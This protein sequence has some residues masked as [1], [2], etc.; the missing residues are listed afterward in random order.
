LHIFASK[1]NY[2]VL[3]HGFKVV[4]RSRWLVML[5]TLVSSLDA[6]LGFFFDRARF[7]TLSGLLWH[8]RCHQSPPFEMVGGSGYAIRGDLIVFL[9]VLILPLAHFGRSVFTI[10][11]P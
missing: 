7:G 6:L 8:I 5:R 2:H 3:V 1:I 11:R 4:L 9:L 10:T